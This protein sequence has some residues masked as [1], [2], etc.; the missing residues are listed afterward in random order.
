MTLICSETLCLLCSNSTTSILDRLRHTL[1]PQLTLARPFQLERG[2]LTLRHG[3]TFPDELST[4]SDIYTP[5][6]LAKD[7]PV[8]RPGR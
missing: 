4:I 2:R 1:H 8:I 3:H 6:P 5:S 7:T